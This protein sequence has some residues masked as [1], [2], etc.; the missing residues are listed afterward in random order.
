MGN[1]DILAHM[2]DFNDLEFHIPADERI[3]IAD[4]TDIDLR[5]R[6]KSIDQ[7]PDRQRC[8]P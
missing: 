7:R 3:E 2:V 4:R 5:T 1:H 6:Q 8:L